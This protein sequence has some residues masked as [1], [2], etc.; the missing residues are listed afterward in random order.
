VTDVHAPASKAVD[1]EATR[2]FGTGP[3]ELAESGSGG[4]AET[5]FTSASD[6]GAPTFFK[7]AFEPAMIQLCPFGV[8][9]LYPRATR[10]AAVNCLA[11]SVMP[12]QSF[13]CK[14]TLSNSAPPTPTA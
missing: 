11:S 9:V 14:R 12:G 7:S 2:A 13:A 4:T 3:A 10:T 6:S 5:R 8:A 1:G